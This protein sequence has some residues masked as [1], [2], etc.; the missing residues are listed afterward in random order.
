MRISIRTTLSGVKDALYLQRALCKDPE[1]ILVWFQ[2][3][4]NM[5][6]KYGVVDGEFYNFDETGFAMGLINPSI[7]VTRAVRHAEVR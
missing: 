3:V 1:V 7:I 5:K 2:L 4:Q 6:A